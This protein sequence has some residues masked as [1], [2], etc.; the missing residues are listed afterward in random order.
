M[1]TGD[2]FIDALRRPVR[3]VVIMKVSSSRVDVTRRR[4]IAVGCVGALVAGATSMVLPAGAASA[5]PLPPG[6]VAQPASS[7][8]YYDF[9]HTYRS[10][11]ATTRNY[12]RTFPDVTV[13]A[14]VDGTNKL[15]VT[16]STA[17]A[18]AVASVRVNGK[19]FIA[20]GG[21][22]A[23]LQYAF[24]GWAQG[25]APSECYNPT[26]AGA[27]IDSEGQDAPYHARPSTSAL[28]AM[29]RSGSSVRT[30][31]MP[32]MF[33]TKADPAPGWDGCKA[34]DRQPNREPF[35]RGLAPY[36]LTT[37][38][39]VGPDAGVRGLSN[40]IRLTATLRSDDD[41]QDHFD[42][43]LVAYLQR[44]F[45]E[46]YSVDPATAV[47]TPR[48]KDSYASKEPML[49]CT[50]DGGYCMGIYTRPS[51]LAAGA[52]YYT[53]T[54]PP[55]AYNGM[56]GEDTIQVTAPRDGVKRGDV[57]SYETWFAVGNRQRVADTLRTLHR[58]LGS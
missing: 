23:A 52:Y 37:Q 38:V 32:A 54:R 27:R 35:T 15:D 31:S 25:K 22:G 26:Q 55:N 56:T 16:T 46:V 50:G 14:L 29:K 24:H 57:L 21:Y 40:V 17:L 58:T 45:S 3:F 53:M 13:S 6:C 48:P 18:G 20:S 43:V 11:C 39:G 19:E 5:E 36:W 47:V 2:G 44:D 4:R 30:E 34:A 1:I 8:R 41:P 12:E 7:P 33:M 28:Y 42:G 51:T 10:E 49:R 9:V